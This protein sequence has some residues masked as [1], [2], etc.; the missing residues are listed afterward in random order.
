MIP[1]WTIARRASAAA[2]LS[3]LALGWGIQGSS[4]ATRIADS[5]PFTDPLAALEVSLASGELHPHLWIGAGVVLGITLLLGPMFCGWLCPLGLLL[6]LAHSL[7]RR[8]RRLMHRHVGVERRLPPRTR[9][10]TLALVLGFAATSGL[11]LFQLISPIHAIGRGIV[12]GFDVALGLVALLL[13][14]EIFVPRVWCRALCPLGGLYGWVGK[15]GLLRVRI[16]PERAG[17]IRCRRCDVACPAG[18]AVMEEYAL[19]GATSVVDEG[20]MRCGACTE[21]CPRGVLH[22]GLGASRKRRE[23]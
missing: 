4:V 22:M 14:V 1:R 10:L 21:V 2:F 6:D 8:V 9:I 20:C 18:I 17:Q 5:L 7:E 16:D 13:V 23:N 12:L 19:G 15:H 3:W 11:P